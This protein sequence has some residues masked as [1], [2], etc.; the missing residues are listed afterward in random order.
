MNALKKLL[1]MEPN[2]TK[3]KVGERVPLNKRADRIAEKA[4]RDIKGTKRKWL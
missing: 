2:I 4:I 1:R 3:Y